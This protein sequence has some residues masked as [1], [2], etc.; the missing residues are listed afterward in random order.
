MKM[1]TKRCNLSTMT[2]PRLIVLLLYLSD[3][4]EAREK[5]VSRDLDFIQN[6]YDMQRLGDQVDENVLSRKAPIAAPVSYPIPSSI[7]SAQPQSPINIPNPDSRPPIYAK[8]KDYSESEKHK[9]SKSGPKGK[10]KGKGNGSKKSAKGK[11]GTWDDDWAGGPKG[12]GKGGMGDDDWIGVG[13]GKGTIGPYTDHP[14]LSPAEDGCIS[15]MAQSIRDNVAGLIAINP[16]RCCSYQGPIAVYITHAMRDSRT[17]SGFESFWDA[18]YTEIR[19]VS[20]SLQ[21]CFV[22][23]GVDATDSEEISKILINANLFVSQL[24]DVV[25]MMVTDPT[26][27]VEL[28]NTIRTISDSNESPSIGVF[29]VGYSNIIIESVVNGKGRLPFVGYLNDEDYGKEAAMITRNLLNGMLA[30]PLCFNARIGVLDYIGARC[31]AYYD[32]VTDQMIE[33]VVGVGCSATSTVTDIYNQIV[34]SNANAVWS[35][36]DCC[37]AVA[38]AV[39]LVRS[40]NAAN[41]SST[42]IVVGCQDDDTSGGKI[43]FVTTQPITLLGYSTSSWANFPVIQAQ[44][45]KNGRLPQYFP[46]LQSLVHTAIFNVLIQ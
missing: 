4:V 25:S 14:S 12:K 28:M 43:D 27:S 11:G 20:T 36:I 9:K 46:S 30:K 38:D 15:P 39:E 7:S 42:T 32:E 2:I 8:K 17:A 44:S 35:H 40:T 34:T 22:F 23:T 45:G 41:G 24:P 26:K 31:A 37:S 6:V 16:S 3:L 1:I 21:T 13:K 18:V 33:P 5:L 29:N 10:E 19:S